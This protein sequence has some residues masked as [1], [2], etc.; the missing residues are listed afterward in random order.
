M[1]WLSVSRLLY[2]YLV[3]HWGH[4][5]TNNNTF[6]CHSVTAVT[7]PLEVHTFAL[8]ECFKASLCISCRSLGSYILTNNAFSCQSVTAA[9]VLILLLPVVEPHQNQPQ[10]GSDLWTTSMSGLYSS[11]SHFLTE[12]LMELLDAVITRLVLSLRNFVNMQVLL[13]IVLFLFCVL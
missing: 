10:P 3:G 13:Q 4:I 11:H 9:E 2:V 8:A 6:S 5:L 12:N 1:L 7:V